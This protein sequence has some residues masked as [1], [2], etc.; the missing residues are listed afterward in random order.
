MSEL[1]LVEPAPE[2]TPGANSTAL[3]EFFTISLFGRTYYLRVC[4]GTEQRSQ[5]RLAA[6]GHVRVSGLA[7]IYCVICTGAI[8]LFGTLC[9]VYLLKSGMGINLSDA[10]SVFHPLYE[11]V[12]GG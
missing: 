6:E 12:V 1:R 5:Q 3:D 2:G 8:M 10:Q 4:I 9:L 11:L 7:F